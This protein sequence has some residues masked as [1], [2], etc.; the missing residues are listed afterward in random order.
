MSSSSSIRS[1]DD[2]HH[3]D[4]W[5]SNN[6]TTYENGEED[7]NGEIDTYERKVIKH[8]DTYTDT[9]FWC[10]LWGFWFF[11]H[12]FVRSLAHL[13]FF[14]PFLKTYLFSLCFDPWS[15]RSPPPSHKMFYYVY[16]YRIGVRIEEWV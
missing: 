10:E 1:S 5:N 7:N 6:N 14:S 3:D 15:W 13:I 12:S 4:D 11:V 9:H 16:A 2:V 8:T